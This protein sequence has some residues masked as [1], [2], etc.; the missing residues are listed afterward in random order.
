MADFALLVPAGAFHSSVGA[1]LDAFTLVRGQVERL[2]PPEEAIKME[3][4]LRLLS[5]DGAP[6]ALVDGRSLDADGAPDS[7]THYDLVHLPS[8]RVGGGSEA[9]R[10]RLDRSGELLQWLRRQWQEGAVISASGS[11]VFLLAA[12]GLIE[13]ES[14][15][16]PRALVPLCRQFY[17]RLLIDERR[18]LIEHDRIVMGNGLAGDTALM[19]RVIERT[20]SPAM[21][22]WLASV[23]G[24]DALAADGLAGDTL[25]ANA[26]LWL[27]QRYAQ[28][29]RISDLAK[30]LSTSHATLIR[31]FSQALDMGPKEYVQHLRVQSARTMLRRTNRSIEQI[32]ALVGY[33]DVRSF[34]TIF[35]AQTGMTASAYRASARKS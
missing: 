18:G 9:L 14:V 29:V 31:R 26:Q 32:A 22:R 28:D 21:G 10:A 16:M 12:A 15:P 24:S 34:R 17:P 4:R 25:V 7:R 11:S 23:A 13:T 19:V 33:R 8:F 2:F 27:E 1:C 20:V 30:L 3:T 6:V 35:R 5:N